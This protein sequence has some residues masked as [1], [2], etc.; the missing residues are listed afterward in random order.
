MC[1]IA[2]TLGANFDNIDALTQKLHLMTRVLSHR[3]PDQNGIWIDEKSGVSLGH[4]RLSI[5]DLSQ[6]GAQPMTS[7]S[8][9]FVIVFNGE[10]YNFNTLRLQL[11]NEGY[12]Y[13][14]LGNS[15]TEVVLA[16]VEHWGIRTALKNFTGMFAFALWDKQD[17]A[18]F[19]ARDRIGEKPLYYGRQGKNWFFASELK[20]IKSHPDFTPVRSRLAEW[21]YL[22]FGYVPAPH[23]IYSDINKLEPGHFVC[24]N[25]TAEEIPFWRLSPPAENS[26]KK[27]LKGV[28]DEFYLNNLEQLLQHSVGEQMHADVPLGCFLSGGI[29]SSLIT[30]LMVEQSTSKISTFC[31]GFHEPKYNES[32]YAAKVA[33]HLNTD[34]HEIMLSS[35]ECLEII[36]HLG[37]LYDEPL[38]DPSQIPTHLLSLNT[39]KTVSVAL[40]GDGGDELFLGYT[41]YQTAAK[42][43]RHISILGHPIRRLL[44]Y[45]LT[46]PNNALVQLSKIKPI[47]QATIQKTQRLVD[48]L[49]SESFKEFYLKYVSHFTQPDCVTT[50]KIRNDLDLLR[51]ENVIAELPLIEQAARLDLLTYLPDNLLVKIDRAA[52]GASLETRAPF[53]NHELI[54]FASGLPYHLKV[55][56]GRGKACLLDLLAKRMPTSWF[57]RPKTGFGIPLSNWLRGPWRDWAESLLIDSEISKTEFLD[58]DL[59]KA[60]WQS[61]QNGQDENPYKTWIVLMYLNWFKANG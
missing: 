55:N 50:P 9:R 7:H 36:N 28:S 39:K 29:D 43:W 20:S 22:R 15:D 14:W 25:E 41:R 57:D 35:G 58:A 54:E 44:K 4:T 49:D 3:G 42:Y 31:V 17:K 13:K 6:F 52:M 12:A 40:S 45:G 59:V 48:L 60:N 19:L 24:L 18:L 56:N 1:G 16:C 21:Y 37:Y 61:F 46:V 23:C 34:H 33:K 47:N 38:C 53:L 11:I 10:V 2:G 27:P 51:D 8:G 5:L 32:I 30:A 26:P